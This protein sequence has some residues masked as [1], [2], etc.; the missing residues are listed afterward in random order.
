MDQHEMNCDLSARMSKSKDKSVL[1]LSNH[2]EVMKA[3]D[4]PYFEI[5]DAVSSSLS[6]QFSSKENSDK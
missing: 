4:K 1:L 6:D 2:L 5:G 3:L